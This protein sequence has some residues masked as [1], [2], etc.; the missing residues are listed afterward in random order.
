MK[1]VREATKHILAGFD[2]QSKSSRPSASS[3]STMLVLP[4]RAEISEDLNAI[5]MMGKNLQW[6]WPLKWLPVLDLRALQIHQLVKPTSRGRLNLSQELQALGAI[7][8]MK[9]LISWEA[10]PSWLSTLSLKRSLG[11]CKP[12]CTWQQRP[13]SQWP[14]ELFMGHLGW[15]L[16]YQ[17]PTSA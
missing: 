8:A 6:P 11:M 12:P 4:V 3:K 17:E 10:G 1:Q 7:C 5:P 15:W 13:Y 9:W 14:D 2:Y 16:L